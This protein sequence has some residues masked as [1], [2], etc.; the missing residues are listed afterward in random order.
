[1]S[2]SA[3]TSLSISGSLSQVN[4]DLATLTDTDGTTASDTIT[5]NATDSFGAHGGAAQIA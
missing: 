2:G 4:S 5:L 3:T 1:M